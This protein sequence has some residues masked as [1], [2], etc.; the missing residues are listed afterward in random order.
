MSLRRIAGLALVILVASASVAFA[1]RETGRYRGHSEGSYFS[2]KEGEF[3]SAKVG[4]VVTHSAVTKIRF[5]VRVRCA[6]G[7]HTSWVVK[8]G[9]SIP[10]GEDGRFSGH[11]TT[12]GGTGTDTFKG[13]IRDG[14]ASG[15]LRR[16]IREDA[17]GNETSGGQLCT[18]GRVEWKAH[19]VEEFKR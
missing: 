1:D 12:N 18:S 13:R 14:R 11:A 10:I 8:H 16:T 3:R 2:K 17:N 4:F 9:G 7:S 5:E 6:D 19:L 15:A